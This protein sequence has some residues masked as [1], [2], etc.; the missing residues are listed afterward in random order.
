[1][2]TGAAAPGQR[3][4]SAPPFLFNEHLP[5]LRPVTNKLRLQAGLEPCCLWLSVEDSGYCRLLF[6]SPKASNDSALDYIVPCTSRRLRCAGMGLTVLNVERQG[7]L[8]VR[9]TVL[10]Q[11]L[12]KLA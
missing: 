10:M 6:D 2:C 12:V 8:H 9:P 4:T 5:R 7:L 11:V 1:M 3:S